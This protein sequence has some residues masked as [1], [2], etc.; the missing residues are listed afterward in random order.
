MCW[1]GNDEL[2][3][4]LYDFS[5]NRIVYYQFESFI[6]VHGTLCCLKMSECNIVRMLRK[7]SIG[8]LCEK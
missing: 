4:Q 8:F 3:V 5:E 2:D 1:A 6:V 7:E